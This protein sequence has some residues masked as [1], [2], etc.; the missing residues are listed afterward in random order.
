M[1]GLRCAVARLEG[2]RAGSVVRGLCGVGLGNVGWGMS[3][4]E[5]EGIRAAVGLRVNDVARRTGLF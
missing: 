5:I 4:N 3:R 2:T 1:D